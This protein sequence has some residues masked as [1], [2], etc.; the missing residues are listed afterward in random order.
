MAQTCPPEA[1]FVDSLRPP[2]NSSGAGFIA[3]AAAMAFAAGGLLCFKL[4]HDDKAPEATAPVATA[5]AAKPIARVVND[6]PPPPPSAEPKATAATVK[7]A[8]RKAVAAQTVDEE[9]AP[10]AN[11]I[12]PAVCKGSAPGALQSALR[13]RAGA[14]RRCYERALRQ[15]EM[16]EG[17]MTVGV[18]I[19]SDGR[20]C[21]AHVVSNT[22]GDPTVA[23]CVAGLMRSGSLPAP[24]GGCVDV[25]V[26]MSF[27]PQK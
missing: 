8:P 1:D 9:P 25:Q 24:S 2:M 3:L 7:R 27:V 26:P 17:R 5:T 4:R 11:A 21:S 18:R 20:V 6:A 13:S 14:A 22:L 23:S 10:D 15:N 12:C 16:L 19:G